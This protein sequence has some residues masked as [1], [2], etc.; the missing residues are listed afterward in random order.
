MSK[1]RSISEI[2]GKWAT[3]TPQ[4]TQ[5]YQEGVQS[6]LNSWSAGAKAAEPNF[7]QG[8]QKAIAAKSYGKGVSAAGDERW[9]AK[10]TQ[11]GVQ[12]WAPGVAA[13]ASDY[14]EGF[15]PYRDVINNTSLPPRF[16]RG[17]ER[18]YLRVQAIGKA[19]ADKKR[20]A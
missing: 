2:Q 3:V 10:T 8:V 19:L 17:D 4:R 13:G 9:Q 7:E 18:N 1:I 20:K 6:P 15:A 12:R 16:P 11:V 14:G 5:Q